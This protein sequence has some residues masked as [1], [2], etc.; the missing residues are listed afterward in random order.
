VA[1]TVEAVETADGRRIR[2]TD[3]GHD[4][5]AYENDYKQST[6]MRERAITT[7]SPLNELGM[8][9]GVVLREYYCPG[10]G[11]SI[12]VDVQLAGEPVLPEARFGSS[13]GASARATD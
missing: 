10:C 9:D 5:G 8:T 3:C 2:C 7:H 13:N 11:T 1:D 12:A 4:L 6:V